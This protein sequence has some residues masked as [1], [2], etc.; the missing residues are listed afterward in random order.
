MQKILTHI[1]VNNDIVQSN[2][3]KLKTDK[4]FIWPILATAA[5]KLTP[6]NE[7]LIINIK[8]REVFLAKVKDICSNIAQIE[9]INLKGN[10]SN[11]KFICCDIIELQSLSEEFLIPY[12]GAGRGS[13]IF[14]LNQKEK[15]RI[16]AI[17]NALKLECTPGTKIHEYLRIK[18]EEIDD[19]I[20]YKQGSKWG[21][22]FYTY[23]P[24]G[25]YK[26]KFEPIN[27]NNLNQ[28][29]EGYKDFV[30]FIFS[31]GYPRAIK[32]GRSDNPSK[33]FKGLDGSN[34]ATLSMLLVLP[35]GRKEKMYHEKFEQFKIYG[36]LEWFWDDPEIRKF[37]KAEQIVYEKIKKHYNKQI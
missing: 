15:T 36:K 37:I 3:S 25:T 31:Q 34:P 12:I 1:I 32:I 10:F 8:K 19:C 2:Y 21:F 16:I 6:D 18:E 28:T 26:F 27:N 24:D 11:N 7:L 20:A 22:L 23:K 29:D 13:V 5:D 4:T 9:N 17:R 30:Y 35:D 33:R 14:D